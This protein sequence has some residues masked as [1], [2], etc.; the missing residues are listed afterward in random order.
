MNRSEHGRFKPGRSGNPLGRPK[1]SRNKLGE[2]FI[3]ALLDDFKMSGK[4]A[5]ESCR[6][7]SPSKYISI[8]A[9]VLPKEISYTDSIS[10]LSDAELDRRIHDLSKEISE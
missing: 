3:S 4:S 8:I 9:R 5:I 6:T 7:E 10:D 2:E 1:G